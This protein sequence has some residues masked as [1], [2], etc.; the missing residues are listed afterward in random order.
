ML[1]VL[2]GMTYDMSAQLNVINQQKTS[3]EEVTEIRLFYS[4]L[5]YKKGYGYYI[6]S[7]TSNPYDE[8]MVFR[9]GTTPQAALK[10]LQDMV[11][12][13]DKNIA[14]TKIKQFGVTYVL[15]VDNDWLYIIESGNSEYSWF[16]RDELELCIGKLRERIAQ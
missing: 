7:E 3:F 5:N 9:L 15:A 14:L 10:T 4:W 13:L 8:C 11:S 2:L 6:L 1:F 12:L 16:T